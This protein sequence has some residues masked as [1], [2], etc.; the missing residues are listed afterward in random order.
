MTEQ[1]GTT[2]PDCVSFLI[3]VGESLCVFSDRKPM[4]TTRAMTNTARLP[5]AIDRSKWAVRNW[6]PDECAAHSRT[7]A[8]ERKCLARTQQP[9]EEGRRLL[10]QLREGFGLWLGLRKHVSEKDA[11]YILSVLREHSNWHDVKK[12]VDEDLRK[13]YLE[14]F[15]EV[16]YF[17]R[18]WVHTEM[19]NRQQRPRWVWCSWSNRGV[20]FLIALV[21]VSG[22]CVEVCLFWPPWP[23]A[24]VEWVVRRQKRLAQ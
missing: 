22:G 24:A 9:P 23:G 17:D 7:F 16:K 8:S 19:K 1:P 11:V 4:E 14:L 6:G 18:D 20:S 5:A 10:R 12:S 2:T 13:E 21:I 15:D 3:A